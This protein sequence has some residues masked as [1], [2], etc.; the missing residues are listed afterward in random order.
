[1]HYESNKNGKESHR[2]VLRISS[3]HVSSGPLQRSPR[4]LVIETAIL[5]ISS[6]GHWTSVKYFISAF[7]LVPIFIKS[8]T[9]KFSNIKSKRIANP[10]YYGFAIFYLSVFTNIGIIYIFQLKACLKHRLCLNSI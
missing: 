4:N 6:G 9:D 7:T 1:M 2:V 3:P 8:I 5:K 10:G